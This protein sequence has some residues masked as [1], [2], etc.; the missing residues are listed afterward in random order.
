MKAVILTPALITGG[1]E[2]MV[3]RLA[4][5]IKKCG[6][7][8]E[9]VAFSPKLDTPNE[10]KIESA[11]IKIHY[12]YSG[13]ASKTTEI[14]RTAKV[15]SEIKPD[16]IHGHISATLFA[17]PYVLLHKCCLI[18][19]IHTKPDIEFSPK[20]RR[21]L[22]FLI[23]LNKLTLVAV[24]EENHK[25]AKEYYIAGDD[26][27]KYVNNPVETEKYYK[28]ENRDNKNLVFI[29]VSRQDV[30]KNQIAIVR[31][32]PEVLMTV[33]NAKLILLGDGNQH[34]I[35]K[36]EVERLKLKGCVELPG[37][38]ENVAD[39]LSKADIYISVSHR[40]GLPLSMLEAMASRL[41]VI[42]TNVGGVPD[43]I[44]NSGILIDDNNPTQLIAAM[45]DLA[46]DGEKRTLFGN[47]G[48]E[49]AKQ[50][51]AVKCAKAYWEI[52]EECYRKENG[53]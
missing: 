5:G 51:D 1:A 19:T 20:I 42:S 47:N 8:V 34:D 49:V 26:K 48:F 53:K 40:E 11:G 29:N 33:P 37:L 24:S 25:I 36:K 18:H 39:Y 23:K 30:N 13:K 17:I 4:T 10:L 22:K 52:Y 38:K 50:F 15:L 35:I 6:N 31:A 44:K 7:E 45:T 41:P 9:V 3:A 27:I 43:L 21:V 14:L 12:I 2:T 32:M 28:D 46:T 16:V